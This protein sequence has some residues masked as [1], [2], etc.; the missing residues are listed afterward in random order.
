MFQKLPNAQGKINKN[1]VILIE[2]LLLDEEQQIPKDY[3][4]HCFNGPGNDFNFILQVDHNRYGKHLQNLYDS[5][6][7][8]LSFSW[9]EVEPNPKPFVPPGNIETMIKVAHQLSADFDYMR[10]DLYSIHGEIFF[11]EFTPFHRGGYGRI[12]PREFDYWLGDMWSLREVSNCVR[13]S[14][15]L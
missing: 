8:P 6:L 1:A 10:I 14:A 11:G 13:F 15:L 9:D 3:K 4:F 7:N 5:D 2:E 12:A